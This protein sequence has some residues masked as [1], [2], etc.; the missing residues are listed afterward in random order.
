MAD[1]VEFQSLIQPSAFI[2]YESVVLDQFFAEHEIQSIARQRGFITTKKFLGLYVLSRYYEFLVTVDAETFILQN[3]GWHSA[4]AE[5]V[6]RKVWYGGIL[7]PHMSERSIQSASVLDLAPPGDHQALID[8]G[9]LDMYLWWWDLPV[10]EAKFVPDFLEWVG[11][12]DRPAFLSRLSWNIFDHVT[13]QAF[14]A[15]HG[16][17]RLQEVETVCHS[18]EF[19]SSSIVRMVHTEVGKLHWLNAKAYAEDPF[20]FREQGFLA[21]FHLDRKIFPVYPV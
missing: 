3:R 11:W 17:F 18:L 14:T 5:I 4:L 21:V 15:L 1:Q 9:A 12:H 16:G 13:Y 6:D 7:K 8:R 2:S 10:Y 19:S 20:F